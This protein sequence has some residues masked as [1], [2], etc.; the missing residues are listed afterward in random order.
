MAVIASSFSSEVEQ[1]GAP[2]EFGLK[3]WKVGLERFSQGIRGRQ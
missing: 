3:P 1:T 2:A